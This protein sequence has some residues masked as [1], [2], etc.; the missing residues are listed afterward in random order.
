MEDILKFPDKVNHFESGAFE[1]FTV[2]L[3]CGLAAE[4]GK[5]VPIVGHKFKHWFEIHC[6]TR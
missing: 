6:L 4:Y 1:S 5:D 2:Q 3:G